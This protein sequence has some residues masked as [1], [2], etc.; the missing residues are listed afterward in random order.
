MSSPCNNSRFVFSSASDQDLIEM[1]LGDGP[2]GHV[3]P[4]LELQRRYCGFVKAKVSFLKQPQLCADAEEEAWEQVLLNLATFDK[5]LPF[6]SWLGAVAQNVARR[7][8]R[9][10]GRRRQVHGEYASLRLC[11]FEYERAARDR[12]DTIEAVR[13]KMKQLGRYAPLVK[14]WMRCRGNFAKM[15]KV[16]CVHENTVRYRW[17]KALPILRLVFRSGL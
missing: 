11:Q 5:R 10:E 4:T 3:M 9:A 7:L 6:S 2:L 14:L 8:N 17:K 1:I 15:A 13:D 12:L 16:L